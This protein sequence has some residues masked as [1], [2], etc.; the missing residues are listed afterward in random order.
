MPALSSQPSRGRGG[1]GGRGRGR[2]PSNGPAPVPAAGGGRGESLVAPPL[3]ASTTRT[4]T[5]HKPNAHAR[6]GVSLSGEGS[7]LVYSVAAN[8]IAA[9]SLRV[10]Q[11]LLSVNGVPVQGHDH[12]TS[13]LKNAVGHL[14]L[15]ILDEAPGQS[16]LPIPI[17]APPTTPPPPPPRP[18]SDPIQVFLGIRQRQLASGDY[19]D[20][21]AL[22]REAE[23][24]LSL[25]LPPPVAEALRGLQR[26]L[27]AVNSVVTLAL[28]THN[29]LT[30]PLLD[31][32]IRLNRD[33]AAV[34]SFDELLLGPLHR[35]PHV[36]RGAQR[37]SDATEAAG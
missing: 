23:A 14:R 20:V 4:A 6:L 7:P 15:E 37:L 28:A 24:R 16:A 25:P 35:N 17:R 22:K 3:P 19:L 34:A 26:V 2:G 11:R 13:L 9:R 27:S 10:G 21:S 29:L 1:R 12:A 8:S 5:L 32:L 18:R 30:L 31:E 36:Q 33:F